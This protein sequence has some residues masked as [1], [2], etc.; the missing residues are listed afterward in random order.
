MFEPCAAGLC[1]KPRAWR[2]PICGSGLG[3][4]TVA[5]QEVSP[6]VSSSPFRCPGVAVLWVS[7]KGKQVLVDYLVPFPSQVPQATSHLSEPLHLHLK[8]A[9]GMPA[10]RVVRKLDDNPSSTLLELSYHSEPQLPH[11]QRGKEAKLDDLQGPCQ[12]EPEMIF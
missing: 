8:M 3:G 1:L 6:S 5:F 12:L 10:S 2:P 4:V 11:L 9:T 7:Q